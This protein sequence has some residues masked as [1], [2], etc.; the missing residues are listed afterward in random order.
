M[1]FRNQDAGPRSTRQLFHSPPHAFAGA[2]AVSGAAAGA[3]A[4]L[5]AG[6][7]TAVIGG[8]LGAAIGAFAGI[9]FE[10]EERISGFHDR[11]LDDEIGVTRGSLG[12][13]V[14][15]KQVDRTSLLDAE[16]ED[17]FRSGEEPLVT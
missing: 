14:E 4:G 7:V 10:K 6:P 3:V 11:V 16:I 15:A 12:V 9:S 5:L 1:L 17:T 2:A 8:V 13:P